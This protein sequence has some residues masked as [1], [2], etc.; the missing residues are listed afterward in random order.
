MIE[1]G[2]PSGAFAGGA[3]SD[4]AQ[5]SKLIEQV[6]QFRSTRGVHREF[7]VFDEQALGR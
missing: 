6:R 2:A 4:F 3:E 1:V 7:R 5:A